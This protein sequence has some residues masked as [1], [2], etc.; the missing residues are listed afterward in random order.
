LKKNEKKPSNSICK[1]VRAKVMSKD[2]GEGKIGVK[3]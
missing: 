1:V 3:A 2:V